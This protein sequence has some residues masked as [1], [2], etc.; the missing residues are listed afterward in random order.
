[1]PFKFRE[2][3]VLILDEMARL[4]AFLLITMLSDTFHVILFLLM[5]PVNYY[6]RIT[7]FLDLSAN[8]GLLI[9]LVLLKGRLRGNFELF[10]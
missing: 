6:N 3:Y 10:R 2:L 7:E 8:V 4:L 1:M 5:L 9:C